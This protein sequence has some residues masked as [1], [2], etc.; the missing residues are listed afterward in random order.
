MTQPTKPRS[1]K[2]SVGSSP[3]SAPAKPKGFRPP[4][5]TKEEILQRGREA[6]SL[7]G[8]PVYLSAYRGVVEALENERY[9]TEPHETQK[10]EWLHWQAMA[11]AMTHDRLR[12]FVSD[13][14]GVQQELE[15][16]ERYAHQSET[17]A[18]GFGEPY[19]GPDL[20]PPREL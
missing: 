8:A 7:L 14:H 19:M 4:T 6:A 10:R 13:A 3:E 15:N 18:F 20:R 1:R 12:E 2:K 16:D 9:E 11:L 5:L 17:E